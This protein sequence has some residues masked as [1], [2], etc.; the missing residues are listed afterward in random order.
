MEDDLGQEID[1]TYVHKYDSN[2]KIVAGYSHYF[3]TFTHSYLN[4]SG[5][6]AGANS[7]E[8]QDWMY[9]MLDLKF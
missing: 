1:V 9:V 6:T 8:G 4:G 3:T 5:G 7:Q 2:T